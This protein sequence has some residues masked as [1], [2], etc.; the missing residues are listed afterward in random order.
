MK[1]NLLKTIGIVFLAIALSELILFLIFSFTPLKNDPIALSV[2]IGVLVGQALI[3][4]SI[5]AGFYLYVRRQE[6]KRDRLM[7]EGYYETATVVDLERSHAVRVN[8]RSPWHVICRIERGGTLH[9][10]R[11]SMLPSKPALQIGAPVRVYLDRRDDNVFYVD[12]E[13]ASPS[14]IRHG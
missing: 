6:Q 14:V 11:S 5:G 2:S 7:A 12:V 8:G 4:G 10:Y 3:F 9:E 1:K 13:S